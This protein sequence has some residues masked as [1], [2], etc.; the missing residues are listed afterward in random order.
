M[1]LYVLQDEWAVRQDYLNRSFRRS[2]G[3]DASCSG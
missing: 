1:L 2:E 3:S